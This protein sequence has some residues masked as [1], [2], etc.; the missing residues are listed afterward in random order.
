MQ[1]PN[2][3]LLSILRHLGPEFFQEE[4]QRLTVCKRWYTVARLV[5]YEALH[6]SVNELPEILCS[7]G[8][9]ERL[10]LLKSNLRSLAIEV[11]LPEYLDRSRHALPTLPKFME[12]N[13]IK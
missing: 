13:G 7:E 11:K 9:D 5:H 12:W 1:L 2:E 3:L 6:I 8:K 4:R 10:E